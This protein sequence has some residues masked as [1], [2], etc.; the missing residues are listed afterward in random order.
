MEKRSYEKRYSWKDILEVLAIGAG[1]VGLGVGVYS[2]FQH[3]KLVKLFN[4]TVTNVSELTPVDIQ[5]AI[6]EQ[7]VRSAASREVG[8]VVGKAVK[9]SE[10]EIASAA[11]K[12][13]AAAVEASYKKVGQAVT[14]QIAAETAKLSYDRLSEEAIE[15]AKDILTSKFDTKLDDLTE[16]YS[17]QIKSVSKVYE[18][19]AEKLSGEKGKSISLNL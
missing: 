9:A 19:F 18:S 4:K 10:S 6:V 14:D 2:F 8:R 1:C 16:A 12:K 17:K 5:D 13:V 7:A 15:K 3:R 11:Q